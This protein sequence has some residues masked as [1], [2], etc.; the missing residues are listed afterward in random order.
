[1]S[2]IFIYK[3]KSRTLNGLL[4]RLLNRKLKGGEIRIGKDW[5]FWGEVEEV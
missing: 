1:M 3:E 5:C 4:I 2:K